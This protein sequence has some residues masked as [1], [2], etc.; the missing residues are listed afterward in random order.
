MAV[1]DLLQSG[2]VKRIFKDYGVKV[3]PWVKTK[4]AIEPK[5]AD[6]VPQIGVD[7]MHAE[8]ITGKGIKVGV[9][10]TGVDYNHRISNWPRSCFLS[11]HTLKR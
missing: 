7:K 8:N 2:V 1:Q 10:D 5:M 4:E 3:E 6:S 11:T 9:L